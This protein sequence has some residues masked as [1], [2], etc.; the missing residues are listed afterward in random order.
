MEPDFKKYID[1]NKTSLT[2]KIRECSEN[3]VKNSHRIE[4]KPFYKDLYKKLL[5]KYCSLH[6]S[7][8]YEAKAI[9]EMEFYVDE[10]SNIKYQANM[11]Y[12]PETKLYYEYLYKELSKRYSLL[13]KNIGATKLYFNHQKKTNSNSL[14]QLLYKLKKKEDK[15]YDIETAQKEFEKITSPSFLYLTDN[16]QEIVKKNNNSLIYYRYNNNCDITNYL[17]LKPFDLSESSTLK[18]LFY[19]YNLVEWF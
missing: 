11:T 18:F 19:N 12:K 13:L 5:N 15:S 10:F 7:L 17:S 14:F 8:Y 16:F 9:K 3:F 1:T 6:N 2:I 4:T